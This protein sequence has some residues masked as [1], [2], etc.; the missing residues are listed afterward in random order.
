MPMCR[1]SVAAPGGVV[2]VALPARAPVATYLAELLDL[3]RTRC[4]AAEDR[5]FG[6]PNLSR[7]DG[8]VLD[9]TQSLADN[10]VID[11]DV[12]VLT[13]GRPQP[14]APA[15]FDPARSLAPS[16]T[17]TASQRS[18]DTLTALTCVAGAAALVMAALAGGRGVAA[19]AATVCAIAV[20]LVGIVIR[21]T[22]GRSGGLFWCSAVTVLAGCAGFLVVPGGPAAPNVSLG[23]TAATA[24]A[25]T[26]LHL[27]QCCET[28]TLALAIPMCTVTAIAMAAVLLPGQRVAVGPAVTVAALWALC[29]AARIAMAA[30]S[31]SPLPPNS[32]Y[33]VRHPDRGPRAHRVTRGLTIGTSLAAGIGVAATSLCAASDSGSR[34]ATLL[35]AFAVAAALLLRTRLTTVD[36][37]AGGLLSGGCAVV[38]V[39]ASW[40]TLGA[41]L[42]A[43]VVLAAALVSATGA[44][45]FGFRSPSARRVLDLLSYATLA[46]TV[47]LALW[48]SEIY[49]VLRGLEL[50]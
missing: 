40:P 11:G 20:S 21:R 26:Y 22:A 2:D 46:A 39:A 13:Y 19:A 4:P 27:T 23:V 6:L 8:S 50:G 43:L 29:S 30:V 47:P 49:T 9:A 12:L 18:V 3:V 32:T 16:G 34:I 35:F 7:V 10:A 38:L 28:G 42:A 33:G 1:V 45:P 31:I 41:W 14:A 25:I 17:P 5:G 44:A 15:P 24:A 48:V 36:T 37:A